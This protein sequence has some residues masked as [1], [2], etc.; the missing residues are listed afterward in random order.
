MLIPDR[1]RPLIESVSIGKVPI[2][3]QTSASTGSAVQLSTTSLE[4]KNGLIV[5]ALSANTATVFIGGSTVN[6]TT[7]FELQAGQATSV[8]INNVNKLY[9]YGATGNGVCWIGAV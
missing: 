9:V 3:G 5:Q 8:G 7:G 4:L 2:Y 6:N 1:T